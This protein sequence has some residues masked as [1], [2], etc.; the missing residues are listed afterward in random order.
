MPRCHSA[1]DSVLLVAKRRSNMCE[2]P[3]SLIARGRWWRA[4]HLGECKPCSR[5]TLRVCNHVVILVPSNARIVELRV[6]HALDNVPL[7]NNVAIYSAAFTCLMSTPAMG[8]RLS[9]EIHDAD[10]VAVLGATC[11][12][13]VSHEYLL[14][15][16]A[17]PRHRLIKHPPKQKSSTSASEPSSIDASSPAPSPKKPAN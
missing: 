5:R 10:S 11:D 2:A 15:L 9:N 14:A 4:G 12:A 13:T 8:I 7:M 1:R 3:S 16:A 6:S 17:N